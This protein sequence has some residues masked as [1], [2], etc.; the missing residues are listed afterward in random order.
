M[1]EDY[2]ACQD[3]EFSWRLQVSGKRLAFEPRALAH[4]RKRAT[5]SSVY[6][7][8]HK[9][10]FARAQLFKDYR[11]HGMPR[12]FG[13]AVMTWGWLLLTAPLTIVSAAHRETWIERL[14]L[15]LGHLAG[16]FRHRTFYP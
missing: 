9:R 13:S 15:R 11:A 1:N 4:H 6:R 16:S 14:G 3:V 10:G 12:R 7:Q 2:Q 5:L 8:A